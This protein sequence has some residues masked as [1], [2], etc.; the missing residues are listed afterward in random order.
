MEGNNNPIITTR[1]STETKST[2]DD[3]NS[4]DSLESTNNRNSLERTITRNIH[5]DPLLNYYILKLDDFI[6]LFVKGTTC[7][8]KIFHLK[9]NLFIL[10]PAKIDDS[11]RDFYKERIIYY[12]RKISDFTGQ[13]FQRENISIF[14]LKKRCKKNTNTSSLGSFDAPIFEENQLNNLRNLAM[15]SKSS[16]YVCYVDKIK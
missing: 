6:E 7:D 5:P 3:S 8:I 15:P 2:S 9:L 1:D 4:R 13:I 14:I 10:F 16:S 11:N 12:E